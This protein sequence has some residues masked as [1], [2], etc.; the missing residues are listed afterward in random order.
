[1]IKA[2]KKQKV[3]KFANFIDILKKAPLSRD[4]FVQIAGRALGEYGFDVS[5]IENF[6]EDIKKW[7]KEKKSIYVMVNTKEKANKLKE[8]F[9]KENILC[10]IE[11]KLDKTII[12]KSTENV[13]TIAIGKI[14]EGFENF[15]RKLKLGEKSAN[16]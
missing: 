16:T 5:E 8:L 2:R 13:V 4:A 10:K 14:S 3:D 9:E 7:N 12:V 11:E 6:F 15:E 1:M